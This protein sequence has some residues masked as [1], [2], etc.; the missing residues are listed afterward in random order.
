MIFEEKP[1]WEK[2]LCLM[3]EFHY[4]GHR[5]VYIICNLSTKE[6]RAVSVSNCLKVICGRVI[7]AIIYKHIH[8]KMELIQQSQ[9][10]QCKALLSI[11]RWSIKS[12][13]EE[14]IFELL[15]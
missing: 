3:N 8:V 6:R 14:N 13:K 2:C 10:L 11:M 4:D 12:I 9:S 15:A 7:I 5:D 1:V